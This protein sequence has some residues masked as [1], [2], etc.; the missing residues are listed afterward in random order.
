MLKREDCL[1]LH[2]A[3]CRILRETGVR[4]FSQEGRHLLR[5]AGAVVD[6]DLVRIPPSLVEWA[7]ASA[8]GGFKLY[9]RGSDEAALELDGS[10]VYFGP[11]SDTLRYL[12]PRTGERRSFKL[13]DI[14]DCMRVCDALPEIGFV[15]SVGVPRD[16]PEERSY[17]HQFATMIRN[18][19]KPV[20]FVCDGL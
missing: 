20:V 9:R 14:A 17:W 5:D 18:T 11:G 4:V 2:Q 7:L 3:S 10:Q 6:E 16:A 15:M 19:T 13:Q 12:D 8:P 1:R